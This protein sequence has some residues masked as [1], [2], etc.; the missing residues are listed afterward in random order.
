MLL[1]KK[2]DLVGQICLIVYAILIA[3]FKRDYELN[4]TSYCMVGGWQVLSYLVH[5]FVSEHYY[6][7]K[8]RDHY[9]YVLFWLLLVAA[10][11]FI[12]KGLFLLVVALLFISPFLAIWYVIICDR[13]IKRLRDKALVHLK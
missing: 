2:I 3:L 1:F 5:I 12:A 7:A 4:I 13:E 10:F 8:Q 9:G 6:P 11:L